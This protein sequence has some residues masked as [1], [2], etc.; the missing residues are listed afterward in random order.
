MAIGHLQTSPAALAEFCRRNAIRKLALFGSVLTDRFSDSSDV[1]VLVEFQPGETVG[2]LRMAAM[3]RELSS[4]FG[5]RKVD[6]RTPGELSRYFRD[7]VLRSFNMPPSDWVRLRHM[8]DA[9]REAAAFARGKDREQLKSDRVL[10]LAAVRCIE[11]IGEAA[12]K[13][14]PDVSRNIRG[15]RGRTLSECA[16]A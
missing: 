10:M 8:L 16:T 15:F 2:Y 11:I 9:S 7:E 6:L 4:L 5:G 13:I 1:D 12:S 3:E 14:G